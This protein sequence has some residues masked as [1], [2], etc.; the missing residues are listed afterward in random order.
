MKVRQDLLRELM[1]PVVQTS[2]KVESTG[3]GSF[4][5]YSAWLRL[6][7][8]PFDLL[9][10]CSY[11]V[12]GESQKSEY[13]GK[14]GDKVVVG[15]LIGEGPNRVYNRELMTF[16]K[17]MYELRETS[18]DEETRRYKVCPS[19]GRLL[20]LAIRRGPTGL[21][22]AYWSTVDRLFRKRSY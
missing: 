20:R 5:K 19:T 16:Y 1:G 13:I 2:P 11:M 10:S 18:K 6:R 4:G 22:R 17:E 15:G 3:G 8:M 9:P 21:A 14:L 12:R 7:D